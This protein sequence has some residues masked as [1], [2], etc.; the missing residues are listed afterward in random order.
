[1]KKKGVNMET[2]SLTPVNYNNKIVIEGNIGEETKD[3]S[4]YIKSAV[5]FFKNNLKEDKTVNFEFEI[6]HLDNSIKTLDVEVRRKDGGLFFKIIKNLDVHVAGS[7]PRGPVGSGIE[8]YEF[9]RLILPFIKNIL[10]PNI[11]KDELRDIKNLSLVSRTFHT[12]VKQELAESIF[13]IGALEE[14]GFAYSHNALGSAQ[15]LKYIITGYLKPISQDEKGNFEYRLIKPEG[16]EEYNEYKKL[17]VEPILHAAKNKKYDDLKL[18]LG[19]PNLKLTPENIQKI[20]APMLVLNNT[21]FD[22]EFIDKVLP[23]LSNPNFSNFIFEMMTLRAFSMFVELYEDEVIDQLKPYLSIKN[24][25]LDKEQQTILV[26]G[27]YRNSDIQNINFLLESG[28]ITNWE[29]IRIKSREELINEICNDI[30]VLKNEIALD[31]INLL[32]KE[33]E[34]C[35]IR[36]WNFKNMVVRLGVKEEIVKVIL[37]KIGSQDNFNHIFNQ[38]ILGKELKPDDLVLFVKLALENTPF[39]PNDDGFFMN[40]VAHNEVKIVKLLMEDSRFKKSFTKEQINKLFIIACERGHTDMV[41]LFVNKDFIDSIDIQEG[42]EYAKE[43]Y[44]IAIENEK[45][46]SSYYFLIDMLEKL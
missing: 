36:F 17:I 38:M 25:V 42:L 46:V 23:T 33:G 24:L 27:L 30:P 14:V 43:Q 8:N 35:S 7:G 19:D 29:E 26:S 28:K 3:I 13:S 44:K 45:N 34:T 11:S 5:D 39:F 12:I 1:M 40:Q 4:N 21:A 20:L 9:I 15:H 31:K 10:N 2:P 22:Q 16:L 32:F 37:R 18:L 41:K 6:K